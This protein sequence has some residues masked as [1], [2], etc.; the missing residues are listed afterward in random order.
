MMQHISYSSEAF[1]ESTK[2]IHDA[3]EQLEGVDYDT[4]I[5]TGLSGALVV[6][7][8]AR[9]MGKKFAI[10]RK[11]N[12]SSHSYSQF[13]GEIGERWLFVDDFVATGAT[14]YRVQ[15]VI[16]EL[17]ARFGS[18]TKL[19]GRYEYSDNREYGGRRPLFTSPRE[20]NKW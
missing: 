4:M 16:N 19:V 20:W 18:P 2:L 11:P 15:T 9:A 12:D 1:G 5:G 6:P 8:F 13:E 3:Q 17:S 7:I 10:V 14:F